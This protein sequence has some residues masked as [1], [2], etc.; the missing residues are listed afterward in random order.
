MIDIGTDRLLLRL[1]PLAGLAATAANDLPACRRLI[2]MGLTEDWLEDSWVA[3]MRLDQWKEDPAYA[4]WSIR[5]IAERQSGAIVGYMNAHD[6]PRDFSHGG[7]TG[8][9]VEIGYTIF[10]PWRRRGYATEMIGGFA[11]FAKQKGVRWIRLSI[12]PDNAASLALARKLHA[13]KTG[14]HI[15][16][17]DG[18]EDIYLLD[19]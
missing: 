18:L 10:G 16:E 3:K 9:V 4:P 6:R 14:S 13:R 7:E 5:A 1:V 12:S 15:D 2:G 8:P 17:I 11:R 19:L